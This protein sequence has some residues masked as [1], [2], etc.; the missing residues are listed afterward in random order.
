MTQHEISEDE[1]PFDQGLDGV[2]RVNDPSAP[3]ADPLYSFPVRNAPPP[4]HKE[5]TQR[6]LAL[7]L[8]ILVGVIYLA[9]YGFF[10]DGNLP[11]ENMNTAIA[12]LSGLQALTGA[13]IGFYYGTKDKSSE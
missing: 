5:R 8:L 7:V 2:V 6:L 12:G 3:D 10:L 13:A 4:T 9:I 1:P 11:I